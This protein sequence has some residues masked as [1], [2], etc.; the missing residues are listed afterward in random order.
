MSGKELIL[1]IKKRWT[2]TLILSCILLVLTCFLFAALLASKIQ[3]K[4]YWLLFGFLFSAIIV[5]VFFKKWQIST[6]DI[7]RFLNLQHSEFDE[8]AELFLTEQNNLTLLQKLQLQKTENLLSNFKIPYYSK[9]LKSAFL[10]MMAILLC[11][12][13]LLLIPAKN[14]EDANWIN[15]KAFNIKKNEKILPQIIETNITV[16]PPNYTGMS[17]ASQ[18]RFN[19]SFPEGST[20]KWQ[21]KTS[22]EAKTIQFIFNNKEV[23]NLKADDETGRSFYLNKKFKISG[24]YQV[25]I[26][27]QLSELYQLNAVKDLPVNIKIINPNPQTVIDFGMPKSVSLDAVFEDD[28]GVKSAIIN[29]TIATGKGEAVKFT[30]K[31]LAFSGSFGNKYHRK[32]QLINLKALGMQPGSELYFYINAYDNSGKETRSDVL[33]VS[34]A[35]TAELMSMSGMASGINLVPEYFR[36]QRQI[37][38]DTEKLLKEKST[39]S[40]ED[41]ENRSNNLGIDQKLLR[42]R[43][44]KFL[45][46]ESE[47]ESGPHEHDEH[48]GEDHDAAEEQAEAAR[49]FG[50]ADKIMDSYAHKHDIA[51]DATFFEPELK[52]QLKATLTEMWK[53]E[54]QLRTFKTQDA[55]PFEY[56]AL[57]LLKDLQQKSRVY[58]AKTSVK[59][60]TLKEDKRLTGE[61][62]KIVNAEKKTTVNTLK[63]QEKNRLK[64][65]AYILD[66]LLKGKKPIDN[67]AKILQELAAYLSAKAVKQP[68][69]YLSALVGIQKINNDKK[70]SLSEVNVIKIALQ[71]MLSSAEKT[72]Q[73]NSNTG[74][75]DLY[76]LYLQKLNNK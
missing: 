4:D 16:T 72:P 41:F 63:V 39:L 33:Y 47:S 8:S 27:D 58:V 37:I 30:D 29:A 38:I 62:D 57:R 43:Y 64:Y 18:Q 35:D 53:A 48:E 56:K 70:V 76:D 9:A 61:L 26:N 14:R 22:A 13:I 71:K 20:I 40:K 46:E 24:F 60:P 73:V 45:G 11:S 51:E 65:A 21:V 3:L 28:Y 25:K 36:S 44:G 50:N 32:K 42:L 6:T 23:I 54:L 49:D 7:L 68:A 59:T 2:Y 75:N 10:V 74:K 67:D 5:V 55:L 31:K 69:V 17:T 34:I 19:L 66:E 1:S 52:A 12:T 15:K